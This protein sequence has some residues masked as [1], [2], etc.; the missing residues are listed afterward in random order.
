M[1]NDTDS[2]LGMRNVVAFV[3]LEKA[4]GTTLHHIFRN[5]IPLQYAQIVL[6]E[7][8][9]IPN[10]ESGNLLRQRFFLKK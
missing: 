9:R 3:H 7:V 5:N 2:E 1:I 8:G 6:E 10:K 4:C